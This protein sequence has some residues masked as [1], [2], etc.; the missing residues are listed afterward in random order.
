MKGGGAMARGKVK[1]NPGL[2]EVQLEEP[3][4]R[5]GDDTGRIRS[6][7]E[8]DG[9]SPE[10]PGG[11]GNKAEYVRRALAELGLGARPGEIQSFIRDHFGVEMNRN[12]ISSYKSQQI[13]K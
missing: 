2:A 9:I 10:R 7:T 8:P 3:S 12:H 4:G 5:G 6:K 11:S 1:D 13:K